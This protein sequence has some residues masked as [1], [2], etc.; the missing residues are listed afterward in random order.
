MLPEKGPKNRGLSGPYH[1]L[2]L[3]DLLPL[4]TTRAWLEPTFWA[5]SLAGRSRDCPAKVVEA[6]AVAA[7]IVSTNR[8]ERGEHSEDST[9]NC[10]RTACHFISVHKQYVSSTCLSPG[11]TLTYFETITCLGY[12][13]KLPHSLC[14][15][16][17]A[18]RMRSKSP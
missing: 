16:T 13:N 17:R 9:C 4:I 11:T 14:F 8:A 1:M 15:T 12:L 3:L 5:S 7:A 18:A 2:P 6:H 10:H